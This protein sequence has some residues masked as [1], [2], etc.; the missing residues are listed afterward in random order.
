[1][2]KTTLISILI[3]STFLTFMLGNVAVVLAAPAVSLSP[4]AGFAAVTITGAGFPVGTVTVLWDGN[5]IP[6]VPAIV[7]VSDT[8]SFTAIVTVP[9]QT[10]PGQ[11]NVTAR[12]QS[13]SGLPYGDTV[14]ASATFLVIDM[15]GLQGSPGQIGAIGPQGPAGSPGP[16]GSQGIPG[17]PG[18]QGPPGEQGGVEIGIAAIVISATMLGL[19]ILGRLKKWIVG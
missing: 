14:N 19:S 16:V 3:L 13:P 4:S 18:L 10:V 1:M 7:Y 5:V 15:K 11:H 12:V 8:G 2:K 17:T 9:T 6:T